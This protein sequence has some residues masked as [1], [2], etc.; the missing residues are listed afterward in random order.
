[1][2]S[3]LR[4]PT[5]L[6]IALFATVTA[7]GEWN[8]RGKVVDEHGLPVAGAV[9]SDYWSGNGKSLRSDGARI[10]LPL[11][12]EA[13]VRAYCGHM[14]EMEPASNESSSTTDKNG[15]FRLSV[16]T[17]SLIVMDKSRK[18]GALV[19]LRAGHEEEPIEIR[20]GALIRVSGNFVCSESGRPPYQAWADLRVVGDEASPL[21]TNR[22]AVCGTM[23]DRF[24]LSLPPGDYE[25]YA[26]GTPNE[27]EHNT[28]RLIPSKP[29]KL[30]GKGSDIDLGAVK[31]VRSLAPPAR[32]EQA[33]AAGICFDY[34]KHY[35][36]APPD[37]HITEARGVNKDVK[38]SDY[39]GKWVLLTF[40]GNTCSY[41]LGTEMPN[42]IKFY[43][44]H[45]AQ[46]NQ[47]EI[48]SI[49]ID[50]EGELKS[51]AEVDKTIAPIVKNVWGG[52]QLPFPILFD[53]TFKTW[54]TFG[55]DGLGTT[56]LI[57]PDGKL[58]EGDEKTLASKLK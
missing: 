56:I 22:I 30:D 47:F 11:V 45:Q 35:G 37:W 27:Q 26:N 55:I 36:E 29:L 33:K 48:L 19:S 57:D 38:I 6:L 28:A 15:A 9:V 42:L 7:G 2:L 16:D 10:E 8:A 53:P 50:Y 40:W 4:L 32:V 14:G 21:E 43:E 12:N 41:C 3:L 23:E 39:K 54:E 5:L 51:L 18:T 31:L 17:H 58:V 34:K 1:V 24:E 44:E 20:L 52:K 13:D 49:Y 46:R 25:L